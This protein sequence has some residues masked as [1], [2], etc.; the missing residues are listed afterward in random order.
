[1]RGSSRSDRIDRIGSIV[2]SIGGGISGAL[3]CGMM[4][5]IFLDVILRT[6]FNKPILGSYE[7]VQMAM[8]LIVFFALSFAQKEKSLVRVDFIINYYPEK[9][10]TVIW[11]IGDLISTVV[12]WA[13]AICCFAYAAG[14]L[15]ENG[16]MTSVLMLP[17][18]PFYYVG[19]FALFIF[20]IVL[21][22]DFIKSVA[23]IRGSARNLPAEEAA[24]QSEAGLH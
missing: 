3:I 23:A 1:M 17:Y 2:G 19:A 16:S 5:L 6:L 15:S 14:T 22:T 18:Y 13:L 21:T 8:G 9:L 4:A 24:E 20:A 10:R 12:A 7:V 11:A